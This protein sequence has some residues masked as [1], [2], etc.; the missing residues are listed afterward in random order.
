MEGLGPFLY[1]AAVWMVAQCVYERAPG[2]E[3]S[4]AVGSTLAMRRKT[5]RWQ[6][7][8]SPCSPES[9]L[10]LCQCKPSSNNP[11]DFN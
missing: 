5:V 10:P 11:N 9:V 7:S 4:A 1:S 6:N 8:S 2:D 3:I